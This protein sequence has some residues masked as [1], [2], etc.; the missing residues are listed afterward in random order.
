MRLEDR[1]LQAFCE[2]CHTKDLQKCSQQ[3]Q[4]IDNFVVAT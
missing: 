2:E 3:I 1:G 4:K